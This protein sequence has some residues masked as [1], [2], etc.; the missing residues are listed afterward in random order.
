MIGWTF[1]QKQTQEGSQSPTRVTSREGSYHRSYRFWRKGLNGLSFD[2]QPSKSGFVKRE[3]KCG[4][5]MHTSI[6][7]IYFLSCFLSNLSLFSFLF[8]MYSFVFFSYFFLP[9]TPP[10]LYCSWL[11][12]IY[13]FP[14]WDLP[15]S[16]LNRFLAPYR[17]PSRTAHQLAG[18]PA[19]T[20]AQSMLVAPL[21]ISRKN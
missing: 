17:Y 13:H 4:L 5:S 20:F 16:S 19:T 15:L 11:P 7:T 21:S 9:L 18:Y 8:P 14:L 10:P 2:S 1:Q 3:K 12:L 6:S